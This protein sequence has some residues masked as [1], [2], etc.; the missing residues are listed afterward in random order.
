[1]HT[2][3]ALKTA[4]SAAAMSMC[5]LSAMTPITAV[6][7]AGPDATRSA[8]APRPASG[9]TPPDQGATPPLGSSP[10][11]Q[12]QA[13]EQADAEQDGTP[14]IIVTGFR[15]SLA[16]AVNQKRQSSQI[17]DAITENLGDGKS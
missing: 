12:A 5:F 7:Q 14:D 16:D 9:T 6:A 2:K 17:I 10:V 1:M 15:A 3:R 8:T 4:T 13:I 11:E